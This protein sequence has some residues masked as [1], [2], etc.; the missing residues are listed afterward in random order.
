M[1]TINMNVAQLGQR[2]VNMQKKDF[3]LGIIT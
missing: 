2:L 1:G 3:C